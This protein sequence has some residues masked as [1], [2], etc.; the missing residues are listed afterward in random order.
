[1]RWG[2][3]R[4]AFRLPVPNNTSWGQAIEGLV[5]LWTS[6]KCVRYLK[7]LDDYITHLTNTTSR[8]FRMPP[9]HHIWHSAQKSCKFGRKS[10]VVGI[11]FLT[12]RKK[13]PAHYIYVLVDYISH[14]KVWRRSWMWCLQQHTF[15]QM[16]DFY[17]IKVASSCIPKEVASSCIQFRPAASSCVSKGVASN[18]V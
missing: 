12:K 8:R 14:S 1:M 9:T 2:H 18:C 3:L 11:S 17:D 16:D 4:W 6:E 13:M 15:D 5:R 10:P 7:C